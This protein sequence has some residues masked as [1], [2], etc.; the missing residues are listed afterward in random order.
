MD[1]G[2]V[3]V[4]ARHPQIPLIW[5]AMP[6][7]LKSPDWVSGAHPE[8]QAHTSGQRIIMVIMI[9]NTQNVLFKHTVYNTTSEKGEREREDGRLIVSGTV[10][11]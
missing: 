10:C 8:L 2:W 11:V 4:K 1:G 3:A 5:L 7:Q 9:P 6:A